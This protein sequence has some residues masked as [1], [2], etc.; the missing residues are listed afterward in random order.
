MDVEE[1][2]SEDVNLINMAKDSYLRYSGRYKM[3]GLWALW[4]I[5][6]LGREVFD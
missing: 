1:I 5:I 2:G 3:D 4:S 6:Y